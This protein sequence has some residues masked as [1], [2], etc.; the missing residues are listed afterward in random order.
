MNSQWADVLM[1]CVMIVI[2]V[3]AIVCGA[4]ACELALKALRW[5]HQ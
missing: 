5:L 1:V 3:A 4:A 2:A